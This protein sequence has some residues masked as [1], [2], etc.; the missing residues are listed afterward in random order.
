M[1]PLKTFDEFLE[2]GIMKKRT[3]DIAR[4]NS[5]LKEAKKRKKFLHEL[6]KKIGLNDENANYFVENSYDTLIELIR[7]KLLIQG[8]Y[9]SGGGAHE[10]EVSFMRNLGF[11]EKEARFMNDLRYFRNGILY[12]GK[13]FDAS[14]GNKV[15]D[16]LNKLYPKLM[17]FIM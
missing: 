6:F 2:K 11:P 3:P 5:L 7:A 12:Y 16:F 1:R 17:E 4:A 10:A 14:Y 8:F 9:A 15:L 13:D